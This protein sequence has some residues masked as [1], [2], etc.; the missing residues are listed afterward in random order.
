V[1][2]EEPRIPELVKVID[3]QT[4]RPA[5]WFW[6]DDGSSNG[7]YQAIIDAK[8]T[9]PIQIF[10]VEP[11]KK[12]GE[13]DTIGLAHSQ[14]HPYIK[15]LDFDYLGIADADNNFEPDYFE[16]M[17][18]Y[19]DHNPDVGT[20]AAQ[21]KQDPQMRNPDNP[22]GGGKV[23][24]WNVVQSFESYWDLAPDTYLN[25]KANAIGLKSVALQDFFIDAKP[26]AIFTA[27]G[28]FRYGRR[29]YYVTRPI[30]LVI[31]Q[32]FLFAIGRDYATE[33]LRGFWQEW[34][35]GSWRC[36]DPDVIYHY[37]IRNRYRNF[38]LSNIKR[39]IKRLVK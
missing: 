29:M 11:Q 17:C 10:Q 37:S 3:A 5:L 26:T 24:R 27:K 30:V 9:I 25:I 39:I 36:N 22:M 28:R 1:W 2:N 18:R 38:G 32:A 8:T 13:L 35:K 6:I 4:L 19:M 31:Y 21:V 33:Y 20:V 34:S 7:S 12:R 15:G 16:R 14:A 23:V